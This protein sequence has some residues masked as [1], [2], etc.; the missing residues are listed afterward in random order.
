[1]KS[2]MFYSGNSSDIDDKSLHGK[3]S[4]GSPSDCPQASVE[5]TKSLHVSPLG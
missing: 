4:P 3:S 2:R 1:M 5:R